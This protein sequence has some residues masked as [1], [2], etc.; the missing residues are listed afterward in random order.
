MHC[1]EQHK[2]HCKELSK[3]RESYGRSLYKSFQKMNHEM[4]QIGELKF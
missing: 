1:K 4:C 3:K 2:E